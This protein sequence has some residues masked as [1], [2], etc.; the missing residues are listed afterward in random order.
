MPLDSRYDFL[1][2]IDRD[3]RPYLA[4]FSRYSLR[5]VQRLYLTTPLTFKARRR[6]SSGTICVNFARS[7]GMARIKNGVETLGKISTC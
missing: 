1:L 3:P 4:P 7:S 5:H 6:A 2:V